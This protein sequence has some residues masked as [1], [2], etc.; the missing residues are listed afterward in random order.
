MICRSDMRENRQRVDESSPSTLFHQLKP[1]ISPKRGNRVD[2]V[3]LSPDEPNDYFTS[4]G[5]QTRESVLSQFQRSSMGPLNVPLPRVNAGALTLTPVTLD[6][7]NIYLA[8]QTGSVCA[9]K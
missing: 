5:V 3:D 1:V 2:P 8:A 7:L 9:A 6:Q 4:V